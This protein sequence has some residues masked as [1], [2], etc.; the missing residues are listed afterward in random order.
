MK[1]L[2]NK[3]APIGVIDSGVGG[4]TVLKRL[5]ELL[6]R[7]H[8][9][10]LGDTARTPYGSRDES[11]VRSFVQQMLDYLEKQQVKLVV[12]ACNTLS[13]LGIDT[14][15]KGRLFPIVGMSK[16]AKLVLAASHNKNIG[17]FAT[18][19]T[20]K[21]HAH[22]NAIL[23]LNP[24][25]NLVPQAC[26]KIVPLIEGEAFGS[27]ELTKVITDYAACMQDAGVDT[28]ILAC[29][30]YPFIK[31]EIE[32]AVGPE[33]AVIDPA[34]QTALD[35]K[36]ILMENNLLHDGVGRSKIVFTK[37]LERGKRL[38]ARMF[39][40]TDCEFKEVVL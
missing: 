39:T 14:L 19:F 35:T 22:A 20:I 2:L 5:K 24:E 9:I 38:A 18:E 15:Q 29:T 40:V 11:T 12:V 34:E 4:L 30:H 31:K 1:T 26:P 27:A 6:P 33:V 7:E 25:V 8:F 32:Q 28:I 36:T 16:G 37:D 13:V 17:I 3:N 21:S 23:T 10:Y